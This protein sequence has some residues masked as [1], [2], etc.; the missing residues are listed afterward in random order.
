MDD[1]HR[2]NGKCEICKEPIVKGNNTRWQNTEHYYCCACLIRLKRKMELEEILIERKNEL[3]EQLGEIEF[4]L[5]HLKLERRK[6]HI[7]DGE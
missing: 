5:Y 1:N 2:I 7:E 4:D 6:E 3:F